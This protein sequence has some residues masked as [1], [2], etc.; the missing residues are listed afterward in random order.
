MSL[1]LKA[2]EQ[3]FEQHTGAV[4]E[5]IAEVKSK[6]GEALIRV[7]DVEQK[8]SRRPGLDSG[9]ALSIGA[10]FVQSD[11]FKSLAGSH[12]KRGRASLE[13]KATITTAATDA[14]GSAGAGTVQPYRDSMV[15]LVQRQLRLRDLIPQVNVSSGSVEVPRIK[16]ST[17]NAASVAEAAL[18]PQSDLQLELVP[19]PI[20]V[21]AHFMLASRQ[22]L[23]DAPQLQSIING[24]L[25]YGLKLVE[26]N[27]IL[28]G[29]GT[30]QDL[31]GLIP[32]STAFAAGSLVIPTPTRIDVI[33]AALLQN[34]LANFPADGIVMHPSDWLKTQLL[35]D[36][37]GDYILGEPQM[38]SVPRLWGVPVVLS[39]A[40][41]ANKFLVGRFQ[42]AATIY[43]RWSATVEVSTEDSDNFR[44]NM[45][46]LLCEER[47]GLAVKQALALTYGDFTTAATDLTS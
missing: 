35:K 38:A 46:T 1:D 36:T 18:K 9:E 39:Q 2:L 17:N 31:L 21:I 42:A 22:V 4:K 20:R 27:Q 6:A 5:A 29:G 33:G 40:M 41:T 28:A 37:Q 32:Q 34:A 45:V 15:P 14:A 30:G 24:E 16:A 10:T 19:V 11:Q 43:D 26:E 13:I 47:L 3:H 7:G 44:R 23:D 25:L 12:D 8:M